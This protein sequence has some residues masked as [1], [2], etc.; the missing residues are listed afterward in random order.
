MRDPIFMV[1]RQ[2]VKIKPV[3]QGS[4]VPRLPNL[5]NVRESKERE[6]DTRNHV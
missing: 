5:F 2:T 6:P 3:K 1:D 4:L